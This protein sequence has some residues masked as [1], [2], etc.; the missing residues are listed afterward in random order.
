MKIRYCIRINTALGLYFS[1]LVFG[2]E[3]IQKIPQK[4]EYFSNLEKCERMYYMNAQKPKKCPIFK[5]QT[6]LFCKFNSLKPFSS[7]T[8]FK[9]RKLDLKFCITQKRT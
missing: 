8:L 1:I 3:S 9:S 7:K 5:F 6:V 4:V 2:W